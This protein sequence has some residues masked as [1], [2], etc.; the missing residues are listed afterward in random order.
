MSRPTRL[1]DV[2]GYPLTWPEERKRV[3][4]RNRDGR[5]RWTGGWSTAIADLREEL[6]K[7]GIYT[8]ILSCNR[9]PHFGGDTSDPAAAL[10]FNQRVG[11]RWVL[12]VLAS[13]LYTELWANVK[14]IA[15]TLNRMRLIGDYG[16]YNF[17]QA[18]QGAAY[19]ALPAPGSVERDWHE[20][21]AIDGEP[22]K[23]AVELVFHYNF[24]IRKAAGDEAKMRDINVARDSAR[25]ALGV[26]VA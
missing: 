24:L 2:S 6:D 23:T 22:P 25:K 10:W 14:A 11:D 26:P 9:Q 20:V 12:S 13:D 18:L 1:D 21:L 19:L 17:S 3:P 7:A 15:M 4:P 8:S 5:K 16:V